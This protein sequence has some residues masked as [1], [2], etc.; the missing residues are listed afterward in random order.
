MIN[1]STCLFVLIAISSSVR[2]FSIGSESDTVVETTELPQLITESDSSVFYITSDDPKARTNR[3]NISSIAS[4]DSTKAKN[5]KRLS[6]A[7]QTATLQ[8]FN[9]MIDLYERK[10]PEIIRKG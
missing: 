10:E 1:M 3:K 6:E 5:Q 8:G 7:V 2:A 9:A 4:G